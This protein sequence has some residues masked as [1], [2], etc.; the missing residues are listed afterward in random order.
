MIQE[1]VR[2]K[3]GVAVWGLGYLGYTAMLDLQE[4]GFTVQAYDPRIT[5]Y[6]VCYTKLLR[7]FMPEDIWPG[8]RSLRDK[9]FRSRGLSRYVG[10]VG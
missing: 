2:S 8:P 1:L 3:Q 10:A 6:N 9:V 5:S 7:T 4:R